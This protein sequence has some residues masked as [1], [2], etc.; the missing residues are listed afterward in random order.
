[1]SEATGSWIAYPGAEG[2]GEYFLHEWYVDTQAGSLPV[3]IVD[4]EANAHRI[5]AVPEL[6]EIA[7]YVHNEKRPQF[8]MPIE[9]LVM[10]RA[11]LRKAK[12]GA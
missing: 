10:V 4:G 12:G 11:V 9:L 5:A 1:M 2:S 8:E 7:E 3:A 6:L